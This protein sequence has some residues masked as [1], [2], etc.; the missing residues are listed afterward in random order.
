MRLITFIIIQFNVYW[1][2]PR[3]PETFP[4][5]LL[6]TL[7]SHP[8]LLSTA[9]AAMSQEERLRRQMQADALQSS[10]TDIEDDG[11]GEV[12]DSSTSLAE[13]PESI[14]EEVKKYISIDV[15]FF[16]F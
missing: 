12:A 1:L 6:E 14:L 11:T 13:W 3:D 4:P 2:D 9:D 16:S 10:T 5:G 8:S 15:S 7:T